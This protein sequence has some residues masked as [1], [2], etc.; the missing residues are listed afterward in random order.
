MASGTFNISGNIMPPNNSHFYGQGPATLLNFDNGSIYVN[1]VSNVE[2]N[3]FNISGTINPTYDAAIFIIA[4]YTNQSGFSIHD[5]S[6]SAKGSNAFYAFVAGNYAISNLTYYNVDANAPDGM[7]FMLSGMGGNPTMQN[8]TYYHC[9]VENAGIKN[10]RINDWVTGYDFCEY[11][12]LTVNGLYVINCFANGAWESDFH[13]EFA[14]TKENAILTG[15][16][17]K[18]AGKKTPSPLYGYGFVSESGDVIFCNNT[19][20]D[21][22]GGDIDIDTVVSTP[23]VNGISP[24]NSTKTAVA[25]NQGNCSGVIVDID[26]NHKEL[27]LYSNDQSAV[28]QQIEL[29]NY[30]TADDANPYIINGT[31]ITVH[32]KDYALIRLVKAN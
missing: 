21:N 25:I 23:I 5:I 1:N 14:P 15:C 7:G 13:F 29:G 31:K 28:D 2:L 18:N 12:G 26:A 9:T 3:A 20:S 4:V 22:V 24:A 32:F 17:A 6:C 11:S 10:T 27:V 30:Y 19:A 8:V 16:D